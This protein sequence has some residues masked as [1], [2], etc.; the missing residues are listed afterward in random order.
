VKRTS[1]ALVAAPLAASVLLIAGLLTGCSGEAEPDPT[2]STT[3]T[4]P[5]TTSAPTT[6]S[7]IT[8]P[9]IPVAARAHTPAGAE[10]FVRHFYEQLNT[11]WTTPSKGL[12]STLSTSACKSCAALESTAADLVLHGQHYDGPPVTIV[13][14]DS[15]GEATSG[16]PEV[17]VRFIQE[18][19]SVID[20]SGKVV[21]SD[22]RKEGKFVAT[23]GWSTRGWSVE[24]VK[25][26][27]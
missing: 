17:V 15:I 5:P 9:N 24:T 12:I 14:V 22:Q 4:S 3:S 2:S 16:H 23:L 6:S 18:H 8:D 7:P 26:L 13:S 20:S 10:A 1:A 27:P 19:R 11:A 25:S 21:L